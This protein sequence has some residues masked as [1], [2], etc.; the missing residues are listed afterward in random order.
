VLLVLPTLSG[1]FEFASEHGSISSIVVTAL[2]GL[3]RTGIFPEQQ[4]QQQRRTSKK[5][6]AYCSSTLMTAHDYF[7]TKAYCSLNGASSLV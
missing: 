2:L 7:M 3:A 1:V 5:D 6:I 4:Q